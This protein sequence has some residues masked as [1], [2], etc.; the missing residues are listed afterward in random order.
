[1]SST[2]GSLPVAPRRGHIPWIVPC[3]LAA[4]YLLFLVAVHLRLLDHLDVT[5]NHAAGPGGIW[6]PRQIRA[7]RVVRALQ[8]THLAWPLLLVVATFSLL[9]RSLRPFGSMAVVGLPV[10]VV[11]LGSKWAMAH[12]D[13]SP[14]PVAHGSFPS[15]HMVSAVTAVGVLVLL[16]RPGT[17][18]GWMLPA[19]MGGVMGS[20]L[21]LAWVHPLSDVIGAGLLAAAALTAATAA[22]LGQWANGSPRRVSEGVTAGIRRDADLQSG[23]PAGGRGRPRL[24]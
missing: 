3:A 6:G 19:A 20:A 24:P 8:P 1:V 13:T 11:T 2:G 21:V 5:V 10:V 17:R 14:G 18:W 12:W 4:T 22:R 9:R 7:A 16:L 15:G 23:H